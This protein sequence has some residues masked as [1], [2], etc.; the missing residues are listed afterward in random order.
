MNIFVNG[1]GNGEAAKSQAPSSIDRFFWSKGSRFIGYSGGWPL[2]LAIIGGSQALATL[3]FLILAMAIPGF[4]KILP[5]IF[6]TVAVVTFGATYWVAKRNKKLLQPEVRISGSAR[7]LLYKIGQHIGWHDQDAYR[8][9]S[10]NAW[11]AW[12]QTIVGVKTASNVLTPK[13]AELLE[14]G[15]SEYN[16]I[17]GLLKLAKDS[18]GRS[19]NLSPQI[20]AASDEAMIS[21]INQVALLEETPE[22]AAAIIS[23][24]QSQIAK[25]GELS[26]RFEEILS[27]PTT[28]ADRLSSST[29][30]DNVLDQL[31]LEAQAHEELR[32]MDRQQD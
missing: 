12:W 25:L 15:C 4:P 13:S 24:C 1:P 9:N 23:Q 7:K 19:S 2:A 30:M 28:I 27:G 32:V 3:V 16:R 14:A 31:R 18:K 29:V 8:V 17:T 11:T 22:T 10:Y 21:L 5:I 26:A 6:G 20:Q